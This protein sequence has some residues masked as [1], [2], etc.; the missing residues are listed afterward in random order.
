MTASIF[1][2]AIGLVLLTWWWQNRERR[3]AVSTLEKGPGRSA[4]NPLRVSRFDE[5]DKFIASQRCHCA[6]HL[7]VVSEG[8]KVIEG[9]KLRVI[10]SDCERCEAENYFYFILQVN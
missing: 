1:V 7:S 4:S 2:A 10:R 6:G 5:M 8:G 9:V 3:E